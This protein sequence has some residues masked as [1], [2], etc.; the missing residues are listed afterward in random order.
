MKSFSEYTLDEKKT[1]SSKALE[2]HIKA[3]EKLAYKVSGD[4]EFEIKQAVKRLYK[5]LDYNN[6]PVDPDLMREGSSEQLDKLIGF[7]DSFTMSIEDYGDEMESMG[8]DFKFIKKWKMKIIK[9]FI[10]GKNLARKQ[11]KDNQ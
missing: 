10:E 7:E 1:P 2:K 3:L 9:T 5:A 8:V 6:E 11:F 4:A